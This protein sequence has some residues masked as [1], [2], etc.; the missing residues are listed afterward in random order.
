MVVVAD[1]KTPTDYMEKFEAI[2]G[3]AESTFFFFVDRQKQWE[4]LDGSIG[5][6]VR[7][8]PFHP[9]LRSIM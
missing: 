4:Q 8:I 6:F 5:G 9:P 7:S 1:T 2:G 3:S